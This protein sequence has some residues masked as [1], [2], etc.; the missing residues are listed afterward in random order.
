MK[1]LSLRCRHSGLTRNPVLFI[2]IPACAGM[3]EVVTSGDILLAVYPKCCW[4]IAWWWTVL[5]FVWL[6]PPVIKTP[7]WH[8][9]PF[10]FPEVLW[11]IK[12]PMVFYEGIEWE[13]KLWDLRSETYG[14]R[15]SCEKTSSI[16]SRLSNWEWKI[17]WNIQWNIQWKR[18]DSYKLQESPRPLD[19]STSRPLDPSTPRPLDFGLTT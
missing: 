13:L 16:E 19:L 2:W 17:Q 4:K 6:I 5:F 11:G 12:F 10:L 3:T 15:A 7:V 18:A 8:Q 14:V 9:I 1:A